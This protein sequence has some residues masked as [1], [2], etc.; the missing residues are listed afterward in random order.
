[1]SIR[2]VIYWN[3]NRNRMVVTGKMRKRNVE[4]FL[5]LIQ[6]FLYCV[7]HFWAYFA[8]EPSISSVFYGIGLK[9]SP[10]L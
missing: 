10:K 1:M 9:N 7:P 6:F 8:S 2:T 3:R 5:V 4:E